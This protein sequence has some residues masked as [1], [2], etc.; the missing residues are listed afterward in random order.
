MIAQARVI[1]LAA[2]LFQPAKH[3]KHALREESVDGGTAMRLVATV[4]SS[5]FDGNVTDAEHIERRRVSVEYDARFV[6]LGA[7]A[8]GQGGAVLSAKDLANMVV[9]D[10]LVESLLQ[11]LPDRTAKNAGRRSA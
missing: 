10:R 4:Y 1:Q 11:E 7:G 3:V 6:A 8:N 2:E 5:I 9:F